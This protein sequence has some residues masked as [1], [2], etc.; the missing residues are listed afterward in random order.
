H[1]DVL[2]RVGTPAALW[3]APQEH[4]ECIWA[5]YLAAQPEV[6]IPV[7]RFGASDCHCPSHLFLLSHEAEALRLPHQPTFLPLRRGTSPQPLP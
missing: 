4:L 5:R 3:L 2:R 7:P 6:T 1:I